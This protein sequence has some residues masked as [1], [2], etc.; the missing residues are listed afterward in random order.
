MPRLG[1]PSTTDCPLCAWRTEPLT[2]V[3]PKNHRPGSAFARILE[4]HIDRRK[5]SKGR[6]I[7]GSELG[8]GIKAAFFRQV[9]RHLRKINHNRLE[10]ARLSAGVTSCDVTDRRGCECLR[11]RCH[12]TH[13]RAAIACMRQMVGSIMAR[14]VAARR[15]TSLPMVD[16]SFGWDRSRSGR[17]SAHWRSWCGSQAARG[18]G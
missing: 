18:R 8:C 14:A 9:R 16:A 13:T 6:H 3:E 1:V 12:T 5:G 10:L 17:S 2:A 11:G 7:D 4:R 15:A